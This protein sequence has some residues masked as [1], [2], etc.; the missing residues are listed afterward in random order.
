MILGMIPIDDV[1][2]VEGECFSHNSWSYNSLLS[3]INQ[4]NTVIITEYWAEEIVGY[5][6]ATTIPPEAELL[7]IAVL[8]KF[9]GE[10]I[11]E[12]L[13]S[14]LITNLKFQGIDKLF[15]EVRS[16]NFAALNLYK[17]MGFAQ[18]GIRKK[19]YKNP[20]DDAVVMEKLL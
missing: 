12:K 8:P 15:L 5:I 18:I 17:K 13:F 20:S 2:K 19:Y 4:P 9:R 11:G 1:F 6:M 7:K 16:E 10:G 3:Q 14:H